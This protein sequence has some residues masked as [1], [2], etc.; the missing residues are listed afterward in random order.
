MP[1]G[2]RA[3]SGLAERIGERGSRL[4]HNGTE[5]HVEL[6][7]LHHALEAVLTAFAERGP[8]LDRVVAVGHR[9]VHG[10]TRF[11]APT[12]IDDAVEAAIEE[13]APLAPLH[14]PANL[15]GIRLAR[16]ALPGVPHVA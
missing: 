8:G 12:E 3:V 4:I 14:N 2:G 7:D 15:D 1:S 5:I 16:R 13:L 9:V 6:P 11:S 10:G